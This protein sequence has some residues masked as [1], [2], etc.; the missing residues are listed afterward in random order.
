MTRTGDSLNRSLEEEKDGRPYLTGVLAIVEA[1]QSGLPGD[2]ACFSA[3]I[4][5]PDDCGTTW[6]VR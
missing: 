3:R 5:P 1:L 2:A 4:V 6:L